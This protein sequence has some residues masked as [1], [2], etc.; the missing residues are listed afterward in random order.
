MLNVSPV[1][2]VRFVLI[3]SLSFSLNVSSALLHLQSD[4]LSLLVSQRK[5]F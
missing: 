4:I 5:L 1:T 3:I 2:S